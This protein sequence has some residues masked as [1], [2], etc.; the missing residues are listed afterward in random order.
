MDKI[1]KEIEKL[2]EKEK[3]SIKKILLDIKSEKF[4]GYDFKKLKGNDNI[5]RIRKGKIR[6]IFRKNSN[7]CSILTIERRSNNTYNKY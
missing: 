6:I 3:K 1:E 2:S 7:G 5:F 4:S